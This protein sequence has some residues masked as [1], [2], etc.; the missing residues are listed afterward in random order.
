MTISIRWLQV[1]RHFVQV[2]VLASL[3]LVPVIARYHNYLASRDI[4]RVMTRWEGKLPGHVISA[5]DSGFRMLPNGEKERVGRMQRNRPQLIE[6]TQQIRGSVWSADI[7]SLSF[8]DPLAVAESVIGSRHFPWILAVGLALPLVLT[9]IF[10]R[11][12]CSWICPAGLL[13]EI[14]DGIRS[15]L[16]FLEV[17]PRNLRMSRGTKYGLLVAGLALTFFLSAPVLGYIYPPAVLGR[18]IHD[19][20]FAA[21]DRAEH[22]R[23][24]FWV[25][26][27]SW[28][29]VVM[30]A[31]IAI[32]LFVSRRWWCR[33]VCP[34]GALYSA[35]GAARPVRVQLDRPT[36]TDVRALCCCLPHGA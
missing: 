34:G 35:I 19:F 10:G 22:G 11:V 30:I 3:F 2:T 6:Y 12:F 21:F 9:L 26:G 24:G 8:T 16:R 23:F 14:N 7:G 1:F 27:M 28:M 36:C 31:I 32:E 15:V 5:V 20:V 29:A 25:G 18:E 17:Q 13:F 33:Y 4:D